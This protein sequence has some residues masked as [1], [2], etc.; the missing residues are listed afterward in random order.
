MIL[1]ALVRLCAV[2][3]HS[4]ATEHGTLHVAMVAV[5]R[6]GNLLE[7]ESNASVAATVFMV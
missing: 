3:P 1:S 4:D 5:D 6:F 2:T 7:N